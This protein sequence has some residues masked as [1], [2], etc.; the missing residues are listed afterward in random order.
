MHNWSLSVHCQGIEC[1]IID[2]CPSC[3]KL[4]NSRMSRKKYIL[5]FQGM[6]EMWGFYLV[7]KNAWMSWNAELSG[8][9]SKNQRM[10]NNSRISRWRVVAKNI[11]WIANFLK[12][13]RLRFLT[14]ASTLMR[15]RVWMDQLSNGSFS[16]LN[17]SS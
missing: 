9:V 5:E 2:T 11:A 1:C 6:A 8:F 17:R 15:M 13:G 10:A 3:E 14:H 12:F 16:K 7:S 4:D